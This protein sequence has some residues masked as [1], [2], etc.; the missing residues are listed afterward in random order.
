M[1]TELHIYPD[2]ARAKEAIMTVLDMLVEGDEI[3]LHTETTPPW[4]RVSVA[5][6]A[7]VVAK[8]RG[9]G[10]RVDVQR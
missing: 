10:A 3:D 6:P 4:M 5:D 9:L 2:L 8:M 1:N 7:P